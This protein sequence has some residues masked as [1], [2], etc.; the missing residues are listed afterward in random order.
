MISLI[1]C[2]PC[3]I[4][5]EEHEGSA[6][7]EAILIMHHS[8]TKHMYKNIYDRTLFSLVF[9]GLSFDSRLLLHM[10]IFVFLIINTKVICFI[11]VP[12]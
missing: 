10:R 7:N 4:F 1:N 9:K 8:S 5:F 11:V 2:V 3:C 12:V 6:D